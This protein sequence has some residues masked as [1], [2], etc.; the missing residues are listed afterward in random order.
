M[1]EVMRSKVV[2]TSVILAVVASLL[3]ISYVRV[4]LAEWKL[5]RS[6][7]Q[8]AR[9][10]LSL[11]DMVYVS[12]NLNKGWEL[13]ND[14]VYQGLVSSLTRITNTFPLNA[15]WTYLSKPMGDFSVQFSALTIQPSV[16]DKTTYPGFVY[17][18][19]PYPA[20]VQAVKGTEEI[21]VSGIVYDRTYKILTRSGFIKVFNEDKVLIG[22]LG[23]DI[24]TSHLVY[25]TLET[26]AYTAGL[27][28]LT[29]ILIF[30]VI[31]KP[32]KKETL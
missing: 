12:N 3:Y 25:R 6:G 11:E 22:I 5:M 2:R 32:R 21:V 28:L 14:P 23:V 24:K 20:M 16:D 31:S 19:K 30:N 13:I 4:N 1:G 15:R 8:M 27:S 10:T 29:L 17:D 26:L 18:L 7:L 9:A